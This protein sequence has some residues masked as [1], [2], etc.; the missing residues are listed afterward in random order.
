MVM[1][2]W[3]HLMMSHAVA[4]AT[5]PAAAEHAVKAALLLG[6]LVSVREDLEYDQ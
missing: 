5:T 3:S 4:A 6:A 2:I 1:T